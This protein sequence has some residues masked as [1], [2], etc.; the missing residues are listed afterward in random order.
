MMDLASF[1]GA[2]EW[3]L[4]QGYFLVLL[5]MVVEGPIVTS[6]AAFAAALGHFNVFVILTLSFFGDFIADLLYYAIGYWGGHNVAHKYGHFIGLTNERILKIEEYLKKHSI[7]GLVIAKFVPVLPTLA[8]IAA[9]AIRLNFKKFLVVVT[10]V[11][12]PRTLFFTGLGFYFGQA[13]DA[14]N[15]SINNIFYALLTLALLLTAV[16]YL[17]KKVATRISAKSGLFEK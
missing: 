3:V 14:V 17:Y 13:F 11:I 5:A 9:G 10:L 16:Y 7:K 12:I 6:A 2:F 1:S 15:R 8:L 4:D